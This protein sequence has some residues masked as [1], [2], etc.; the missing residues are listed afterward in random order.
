[1]GIFFW[2]FRL[3]IYISNNK[4]NIVIE[5]NKSIFKRNDKYN[6]V[7]IYIYVMWNVE[8]DSSDYIDAK[9]HGYMF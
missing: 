6:Y 9:K 5:I 7:Y 3:Y 1:M 8:Y 4:K 2:N